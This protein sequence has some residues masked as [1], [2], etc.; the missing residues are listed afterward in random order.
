ME[1]TLA[2]IIKQRQGQGVDCNDSHM[3]SGPELMG[4]LFVVVSRPP[5]WIRWLAWQA[6]NKRQQK[7]KRKLVR[8]KHKHMQC[9]MRNAHCA[10]DNVGGRQSSKQVCEMTTAKHQHERGRTKMTLHPFESQHRSFTREDLE[11]AVV[12]M[13]WWIGGES[14]GVLL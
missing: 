10:M 3:P 8:P 14:E 12:V 5:G 9:T 7:E 11:G 13:V 1:Q 2:G 6:S 4:A